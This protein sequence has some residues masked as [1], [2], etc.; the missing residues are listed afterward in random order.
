MIIGKSLGRRYLF[1]KQVEH[2]S[3][4]K[5]GICLLLILP[6]KSFSECKLLPHS[7]VWR[8]PMWSCSRSKIR[9]LTCSVQVHASLFRMRLQHKR[10]GVSRFGDK[11]TYICVCRDLFLCLEECSL[12]KGDCAGSEGR[13]LR[14]VDRPEDTESGTTVLTHQL[15]DLKS[16]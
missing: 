9:R 13:L 3:A 16:P 11:N 4:G 8:F 15:C 1:G 6:N 12:C 14:V 2:G 7:I 10:L 5:P